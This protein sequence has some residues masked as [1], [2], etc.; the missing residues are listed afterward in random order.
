MSTTQRG[1]WQVDYLDEGTGP[2]VI[3]VHSSVSGN[4]QWKRLT[5][6]LRPEFRVLSPNLLGYGATTAW[7]GSR[8]QTVA[9]ATEVVLAICD[10]CELP[11]RIVGHSWGG[12]LAMRAA[13][14]LGD[15][16]SHLVVYEP[17]MAGLL[18]AHG[19]AAAKAEGLAMYGDVKRLGDAGRWDDLAAIFTDYF[20]GEGAWAATPPDR[21]RA[22]A[23]QLPPNRHEWDASTEPV[24]PEVFAAIK[25]RTLLM[26][27]GRTRLLT[28]EITQ[29]LAR[30]QPHWR[31]HEFA[32][33]GHMGPLT[34]GDA[35]NSVIHEFLV[36]QA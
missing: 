15:A 3:L 18:H 4:R 21:R 36:D 30:S 32:D 2:P 17:M 28:H 7:D 13:A 6:R 16:V 22:I 35:V 23:G 27:G 14:Q 8:M 12:A 10:L 19:S 24:D 26:R 33:A 29:I 5:E 31:L 20:N 1:A 34:H 11:L 25:A 9:A